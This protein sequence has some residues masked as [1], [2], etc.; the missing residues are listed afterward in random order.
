MMID[1]NRECKVFDRNYREYMV[2]REYDILPFESDKENS[3][4]F[5]NFSIEI[6]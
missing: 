2:S 5:L 1:L 6:A 3:S 4:P